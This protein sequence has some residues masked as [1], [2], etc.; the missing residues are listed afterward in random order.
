MHKVSLWLMS[1]R[2]RSGKIKRFIYLTGHPFHIQFV[3]TRM[4]LNHNIKACPNSETRLDFRQDTEVCLSS[5]DE[6]T[7]SLLTCSQGP[8]FPIPFSRVKKIDKHVMRKEELRR[9]KGEETQ[10]LHPEDHVSSQQF[11]IFSV[12]MLHH[13][14]SWD[15]SHLNLLLYQPLSCQELPSTHF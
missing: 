10:T 7:H 8:S 11:P 1:Q 15:L 4:Q 13:S 5:A 14:F 6:F 2:A 9:I 3:A 12:K